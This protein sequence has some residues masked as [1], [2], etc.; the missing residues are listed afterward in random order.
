MVVWM[1]MALLAAAKIAAATLGLVAEAQLIVAAVGVL[2]AV[3]TRVAVIYTLAHQV[4]VSSA[5]PRLLLAPILG[6]TM[7]KVAS[8]GCS[9]PTMLSKRMTWR[10]T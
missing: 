3:Q 10:T 6:V 9:S 5:L 2:A 1:E 7:L 4:Q 8:R